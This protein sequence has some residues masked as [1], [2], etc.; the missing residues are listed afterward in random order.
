MSKYLRHYWLLNDCFSSHLTQLLLLHYLRKTDQANHV[1][2]WMKKLQYILSIQISA[3][4]SQSI[5]R[6]DCHKAVCL[7][8]DVQEC[9]WIQEVTGEVWISLK[10]KIINTA[11]NECSK[12]LH[13][14]VRTMR[15]HV[16]QFCCRQMKTKQLDET[17]ANVPR[18]LLDIPRTRSKFGERSFTVAGPSAWNSLPANIRSA[19]SVDSFK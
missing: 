9:L 17:S 8:D 11:V 13:E 12:R 6:F 15:P 4:K 1:L 19:A 2:K 5:T 7:P 18:H 3:L 10:Q 16:K 14:C